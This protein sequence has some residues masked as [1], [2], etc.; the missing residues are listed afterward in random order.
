MSSEEFS[1]FLSNP[2][3]EETTTDPN[4]L[5]EG[6]EDSS[7]SDNSISETLTLEEAKELSSTLK[8]LEEDISYFDDYSKVKMSKKAENTFRTSLQKED[9]NRFRIKDKSDRATTEQVLDN[10]TLNILHK[11]Q[12]REVFSKL[13][14]CISTGKEA[15]VYEA[16]G[17]CK[18]QPMVAIKIYK[19]SIL[20]F[21]DR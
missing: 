20:I 1:Y 5:D 10:K 6:E 3:T 15:N 18:S 13:Q 2:S 9:Q 19:T 14:G 4:A 21:K 17:P 16:V 7:S 11:F 12:K 8:T